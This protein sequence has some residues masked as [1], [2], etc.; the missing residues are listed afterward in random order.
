[1]IVAVQSLFSPSSLLL[2]CPFYLVYPYAYYI[3]RF[4]PKWPWQSDYVMAKEMLKKYYESS[5]ELEAALKAPTQF[6]GGHICS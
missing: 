6:G 3:S 4:P 5:L 1:M 2:E